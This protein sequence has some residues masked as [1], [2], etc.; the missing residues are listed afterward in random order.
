MERKDEAF[1]A[2]N[3]DEK[4]FIKRS[5]QSISLDNQDHEGT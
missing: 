5:S 4:G 2:K 3:S 1:E